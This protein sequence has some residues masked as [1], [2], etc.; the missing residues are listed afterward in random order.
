MPA[1]ALLLLDAQRQIKQVMS[2]AHRT[3]TDRKPILIVN[4]VKE[5]LQLI[6]A[7]IP[8]SVKINQDICRDSVMILG[9]PTEISQIIMNL[10]SNSIHAMEEETGSGEDTDVA[11]VRTVAAG[12]ARNVKAAE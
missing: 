3:P 8:R 1:Q 12:K 5:S 9:N 6:H 7:T 10:F 2:F 4:T 11:A